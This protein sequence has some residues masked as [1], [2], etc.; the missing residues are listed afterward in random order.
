[1]TD[2]R[3]HPAGVD[4]AGVDDVRAD[5][6]VGEFD[7]CGHNDP[8]QGTLARTV[9]QVVHR[10]VT[11][12]S[13]D[14]ASSLRDRVGGVVLGERL[15]QQPHRAGIDREVPVPALDGRVKH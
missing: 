14:P 13:D 4:R 8:V 9:G 12:Q 1:M 2:L 7:P 3:A 11:R 10:M 5:P 6:P 15:D